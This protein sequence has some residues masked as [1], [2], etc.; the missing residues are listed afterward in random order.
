MRETGTVLKGEYH[1]L[2]RIGE[3]GFSKAYLAERIS[4]GALVAVKEFP[5]GKQCGD[6]WNLMKR[7]E[8]FS[9][10]AAPIECF[11]ED[12]TSYIVMEH[13][14]GGSMKDNVRSGGKYDADAVLDAIR[15][16]LSLLEEMHK[17]GYVHGD[18]SPDNL[19][20]GE[21][22]NYKLIDFGAARRIGAAGSD[23]EILRKEGY[24]PAENYNKHNAADPR[25][26]IY[27]VC[28][29]LY[30]A[31]TG[32]EP[33]DSLERMLL[34]ELCPLSEVCPEIDPAVDHLVM[35]G[36]SM[37]PDERWGSIG[38]ISEEIRQFRKSEDERRR[39]AEEIAR[40]QRR[41][42]R[43]I[44]F[45]ILAAVFAALAVWGM[46]HQE[47]LKFRGA[48]TQKI[49]IYYDN[50]M[51]AEKVSRLHDNI[52]QKMEHIAGDGYLLKKSA[53]YYEI[54]TA[55]DLFS[56]VDLPAVIHRYFDFESC[57]IGVGQS[58]SFL[59]ISDLSMDQI[60]SAWEEEN[61][62]RLVLSDSI[63]GQIRENT[64]AASMLQLRINT[65]G[66]GNHMW[67]RE[68]TPREGEFYTMDADY[69]PEKGQLFISD[70]SLGGHPAGALFIDC[71]SQEYIPISAFN[72]SRHVIWEEKEDPKWGELTWGESAWGA[73]QVEESQLYGDTVLLEYSLDDSSDSEDSSKLIEIKGR[74]DALK[75]PYACGWDARNK[76]EFYVSVKEK[77]IWEI[78]AALLFGSLSTAE[79]DKML[80]DVGIEIKTESGIPFP[81]VETDTHLT[82]DHGKVGVKISDVQAMQEI[83]TRT[84]D[85]YAQLCLEGRPVFRTDL[86]E[87][88]DDGWVYF[89][90]VALENAEGCNDRDI[91]TF[92]RFVNAV[93]DQK[94][95]VI[96]DFLGALFENSNGKINWNKTVWDLQCCENTALREEIYR[97]C[98]AEGLS[99][100]WYPY[101]P[102]TVNIT[103]GYDD[104]LKGKYA[105]PYAAAEEFL[106]RF[107]ITNEI[108]GVSL[109][110]V[111]PEKSADGD[112]WST[113]YNM[114]ITRNSKNGTREI[115]WSVFL[116]NYNSGPNS[117]MSADEYTAS[118]EE[119]A[120]QYIASKE[121]FESC[122]MNPAIN[123]IYEQTAADDSELQLK[124]QVRDTAPGQNYQILVYTE[125]RTAKEM[126]VALDQ[127][128]VNNVMTKI[129]TGSRVLEPYES[130]WQELEFSEEDL[131]FS[132]LDPFQN[133]LM[134]FT[135]TDG[136]NEK[137]ISVR[138]PDDR[139][140]G[141]SLRDVKIPDQAVLLDSTDEYAVY[142]EGA[143]LEAELLGECA[144]FILLN[145]TSGPMRFGFEELEFDLGYDSIEN[146][147][148]IPVYTD[149]LPGTAA[150]YDLKYLE[151][152]ESG[153]DAVILRMKVSRMKNDGSLEEP[154]DREFRI[155]QS[156]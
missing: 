69:D 14:P 72:Y 27:S 79:L 31:L 57:S 58:G 71:L 146:S 9:G 55:Y 154:A 68:N 139:D 104:R 90:T 89:D 26:D 11:E 148:F 74:L 86:S 5:D 81:Y 87:I 22:G 50:A 73:Y 108:D 15:Q 16:V 147:S 91:E 121:I 153:I 42:K 4:D 127:M 24:T 66:C 143:G 59:A 32:I 151:P 116:W 48:E 122:Y 10:M 36:L 110:L 152:M 156:K 99:A 8:A 18:I 140:I 3:G 82:A 47:L 41:R 134:E 49:V 77:E 138:V 145:K 46:M 52:A 78:E 84:E 95:V 25:S 93:I 129:S 124:V 130:G 114:L 2:L 80:D 120:R 40:G 35:K 133:M 39:E 106:R 44:A 60:D 56:E 62:I 83:L 75:I 123:N 1:I 30:Y 126:E 7:F 54:T 17:G 117:S 63:A 112:T 142:C 38:E 132:T 67:D 34:D 92:A 21:D 137:H 115:T 141:R 94:T 12:S 144:K 96:A 65:E 85:E 33:M 136:Q 29:T 100:D 76:N 119:E 98:S 19:V 45:G 135:I 53:G 111:E 107:Q 70:Q 131:H 37:D 103:A 102:A 61:G 125:N 13:L 97:F 150:Y 118:K 128:A 6:E 149:V 88:G 101:E 20:M 51:E 109:M 155:E 105:H 113:I 28:A 43:F 23:A 64:E